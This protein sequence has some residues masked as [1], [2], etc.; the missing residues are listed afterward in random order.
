MLGKFARLTL[1]FAAVAL[2]ACRGEGSAGIA[3]DSGNIAAP[4]VQS[5]TIGGSPSQGAVS[6]V[7]YSFQPVLTGLAGSSVTFSISNKPAWA[8]FSVQTG[9]LS[10]TPAPTD[11]GSQGGILI[12]ASNGQ[13]T[14]TLPEFTITVTSG[15][16]GVGTA[17]L[18]WS[19]PTQNADGSPLKALAGYWIYVGT[20]A[21]AL[22][23]THQVTDPNTTSHQ[24]RGLAN[25]THYFAISAYNDS[26]VES[27]LS[28]VG[29]KTIS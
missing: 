21:S 15:S 10:G 16:P 22:R 20:G 1:L 29:S 14:S 23:K 24:I 12:T 27:P 3:S 8:T 13:K 18:H 7:T 6:G 4:L 5:F 9:L 11:V 17:T 26:G 28:Q 25:G 19:A 2:S